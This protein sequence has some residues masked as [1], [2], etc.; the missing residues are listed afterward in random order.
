LG[1][2]GGELFPKFKRAMVAG[3]CRQRHEG[4]ESGSSCCENRD[5]GST[6]KSQGA[7]S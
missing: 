7:A 5:G 1:S 4:A 6:R 3:G 2:A